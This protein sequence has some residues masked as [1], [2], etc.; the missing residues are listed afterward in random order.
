MLEAAPEIPWDARKI[1]QC[2]RNDPVLS[3]VKHWTVNGWPQGKVTEQFKPYARRQHELSEY[4]G[5]LLWGSRV[6]IPRQAR[7]HVL[8]LL[9][10]VHP[11]IV[12]MKALARSVVWW[13]GI[14]DEIERK[15]RTC[16]QCQETR[17]DPLRAR[18]HPWEFTRNPWA[19][20]HIDFA[21]PFQGRCFLLVVDA[22]SKWLEVFQL[23]SLSSVTV[24]EKLR[25]LFATHGVPDTIVSDNG[26]AFT[27]QEFQEFMKRNQIRHV[28]VAPYHPSSNGQVE[29]MVQ[30]TKQ[31]LKRLG[32]GDL[33]TKL[34]RFLLSQHTLPHST[35]GKSPAEMLMGRRLHT[36]LDRLH[37]DMLTEMKDKQEKLMQSGNQRLR[38]FHLG[39]A[40][41]IRNYLSG[42]KWLPRIITDITGPVSFKVRT[43]D[44]RLWRRHLDQIRHREW[45]EY[46]EP[47]IELPVPDPVFQPQSSPRL[48]LPPDVP[49]AEQ[50]SLPISSEETTTGH[51]STVVPVPSSPLP[52]ER[53]EASFPVPERTTRP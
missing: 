21:G 22:H 37:P 50:A 32:K 17:P 26:A 11:G 6:V 15:V 35:T 20:L 52:T 33:T 24:C 28:R 3:R 5:C 14:D 31:V 4:R 7:D 41:F 53:S 43:V 12:R 1:A 48:P 9:H 39:D 38:S 45:T 47:M 46:Y 8:G 51:G 10:S 13:P 42:P 29:R 44:G 19:R 40:V 2:T 18:L 30:E 23:T 16:L 25:T 34:S 36:V 49:L 27:S